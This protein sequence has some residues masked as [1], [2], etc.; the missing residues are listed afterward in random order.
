MNLEGCRAQVNILLRPHRDHRT[1]S[2]YSDHPRH[3]LLAFRRFACHTEDGSE[4][5]R[6]SKH[7]SLKRRRENHGKVPHNMIHRGNNGGL[8]QLAE[9]V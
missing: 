1:G 6:V 7:D 2:Y 4:P 3:A 9:K 8:D 5:L